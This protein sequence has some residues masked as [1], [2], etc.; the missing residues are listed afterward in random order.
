MAVI[1]RGPSRSAGDMYMLLLAVGSCTAENVSPLTKVVALLEDLKTQLEE[2]GAKEAELYNEYNHWCDSEAQESKKTISDAKAK[3]ADLESF[4][5]E[6]AALRDKI[7][8]EL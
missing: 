1:V 7:Q 4:L 3:I 2:D 6:Q 8:S 5:E